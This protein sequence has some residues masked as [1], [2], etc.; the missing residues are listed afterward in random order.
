MKDYYNA[1]KAALQKYPDARDDDMKLYARIV[2]LETGLSPVVGFY[3]AT[4]NHDKYD[5]PSYESV[6]RAR[7]KV[8][9][10]EP[11]LRGK[12]YGKRQEREAEYRDYYGSNRR[13]K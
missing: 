5:L 2:Y 9:E 3:E 7:R 4:F 13:Q 11:T 6:T 10:Q 1:V 12:K 8:Q